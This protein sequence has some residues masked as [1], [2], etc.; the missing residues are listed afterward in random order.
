ML[1]TLSLLQRPNA[2]LSTALTEERIPRPLFNPA[3]Q[4][5]QTSFK[6]PSIIMFIVLS[7]GLTTVCQAYKLIFLS[8]TAHNPEA[9]YFQHALRAVAQAHLVRVNQ[10]SQEHILEARTSHHTAIRDLRVA[11]NDITEAR[12]ATALIT[13][14]LLWQYD[15]RFSTTRWI[16]MARNRKMRE[17]YCPFDPQK[18]GLT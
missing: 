12:S 14:E 13:T 3:H 16:S 15:V 8:C 5:R 10:L 1:D 11:L 4:L 7:S 17:S 2:S 6:M 9:G 18:P